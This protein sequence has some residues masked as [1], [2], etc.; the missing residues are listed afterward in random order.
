MRNPRKRN[1]VPR[2]LKYRSVGLT[3]PDDL[4]GGG[5]DT[6]DGGLAGVREPR[7]DRPQGPGPVALELPEPSAEGDPQA[8]GAP[9][10]LPRFPLPG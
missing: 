2:Q 8:C 1:K 7:P 3:L 6:D 4:F 9:F 10:P 5:D